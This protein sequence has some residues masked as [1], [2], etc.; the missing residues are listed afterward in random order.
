MGTNQ[1][2]QPQTA[3]QVN[4]PQT[5]AYSFTEISKIAFQTPGRAKVELK[6]V[7]SEI[8][9]L[10]FALERVVNLLQHAEPMMALQVAERALKGEHQD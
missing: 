10:R 4:N 5:G 3:E 9:R 6:K 7:A 2:Q 8:D 1:P